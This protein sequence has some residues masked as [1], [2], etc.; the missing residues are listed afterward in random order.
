MGRGK[1][2]NLAMTSVLYLATRFL[3][4]LI[5]F[6]YDWYAGSFLSLAHR[7]LAVFLYLD[8]SLALRVTLGHMFE[9]LYQDR[10]VAGHILGFIFR[11]I[12]V[13]LALAIYFVIAVIFV[14]VYVLWA[15]IPVALIY[16]A[17]TKHASI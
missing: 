7:A 12:R 3:N 6:L 14:A 8:R 16:V 1:C 9:P 4:R 15:A 17:F 5:Q 11:T 13:I 10:S 2:Y